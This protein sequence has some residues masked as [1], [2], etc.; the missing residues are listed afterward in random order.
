MIVDEALKVLNSVTLG[1]ESALLKA[2]T[3]HCSKKSYPPYN[4]FKINETQ[5]VIEV[6]V[7]GFK[8]DEIEVELK[9]DLL[10][11]SGKSS[12]NSRN[13]VEYLHRGVSFRDF[14]LAWA[15]SKDLVVDNAK[16]EDGLLT[17]IL[18]KIVPEEEIPKKIEIK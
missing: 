15:I 13:G 7:A 2:S 17:I 14:K 5:Y 4:I 10:Y 16:L 9:K 6:A 3:S 12:R 8:K 18:S 1:L 11:I